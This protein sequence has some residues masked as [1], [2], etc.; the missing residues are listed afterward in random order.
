MK[1]REI[2]VPRGTHLPMQICLVLGMDHNMRNTFWHI[3]RDSETCPHLQVLYLVVQRLCGDKLK[4]CFLIFFWRI[5]TWLVYNI[6]CNI[7]K[8]DALA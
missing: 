4:L 6:D 3:V 2:Y 8:V 5:A 1:M 7:L